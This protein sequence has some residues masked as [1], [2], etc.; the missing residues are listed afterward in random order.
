ME[1][2]NKIIA[3][4]IILLIVI[5][6]GIW[7]YPFGDEVKE[8]GELTGAGISAEEEEVETREAPV[9]EETELDEISGRALIGK[10]LLECGGG[11]KTDLESD[12]WK[13]M[14]N[15]KYNQ[16]EDAI[17]EFIRTC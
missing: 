4:A 17:R 2:K 11:A 14:C 10:C 3:I 1:M 16:G 13:I 9:E 8:D 15:K 12:L 6:V 7:L 5:L